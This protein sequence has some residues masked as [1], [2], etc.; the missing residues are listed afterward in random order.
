M[1]PVHNAECMRLTVSGS[2]SDIVDESSCKYSITFV[3]FDCVGGNGGVVGVGGMEDCADDADG[4]G[5]VGGDGA[6]IRGGVD[7]RGD[8][9][10]NGTVIKGGV[11]GRGVVG[12]VGITG[13]VFDSVDSVEDCFRGVENVF[14]CF[15]SFCA[16]IWSSMGS[17][18]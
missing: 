16:L 3:C 1:T 11:D 10:G 18:N 17:N 12:C 2:G 6:V 7:G 5:D 8:V 4:F 9:G 13:S 15:V 14:F